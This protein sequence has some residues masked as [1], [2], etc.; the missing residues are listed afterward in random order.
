MNIHYIR[1]CIQK[2]YSVGEEDFK[3][4]SQKTQIFCIFQLTS[5][6][7]MFVGGISLQFF[8]NS[9]DLESGNIMTQGCDFSAK[10]RISVFSDARKVILVNR[11]DPV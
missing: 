9:D 11:A 4:S 1:N 10:T 3:R 7:K 8:K 5:P 6:A 2:L